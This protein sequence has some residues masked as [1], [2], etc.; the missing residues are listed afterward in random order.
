M[1]ELTFRIEAILRRVRGKKNKES[2][3]YKIDKKKFGYQ[4]MMYY[5]AGG[6]DATHPKGER[7][8]VAFSN[9]MKKWKRYKANPIFAHDS[10]GTITGD[11][12]IVKMGN[13]THTTRLQQAM[14]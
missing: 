8:G 7:I 4:F 5:N 14:T 2:N 11:A 9:D 3:V 10:D 12:Q 13:T 1:E 6:K